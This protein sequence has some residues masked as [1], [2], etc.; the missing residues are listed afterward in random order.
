MISIGLDSDST[1]TPY[2][3]GVN[4]AWQDLKIMIIENVKICLHADGDVSDPLYTYD[5]E[6]VSLSNIVNNGLS[7]GYIYTYMGV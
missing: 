2:A 4:L 1:Y 5:I 6:K 7:S 3:E